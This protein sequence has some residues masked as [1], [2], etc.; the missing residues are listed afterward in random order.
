MIATGNLNEDKTEV[1]DAL[2]GKTCADLAELPNGRWGAVGANLD[3]IPVV[4]GG[5]FIIGSPEITKACFKFTNGEWKEFASMKEGR[6]WAAGIVYKN[7][8]H[9][10]GGYNGNT[11]SKRLSSSEIISIEGG[12]ESGPDMADNIEYHAITTINATTSILSGG[13][14]LDGSTISKTWY[15]NHETQVFTDGP[16]LQEGRQ[17]HGSAT[18]RDRNNSLRIPI[19]TGG[20]N[21]DNTLNSTEL[22]INGKWQTGTISWQKKDPSFDF[23]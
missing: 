3:G 21:G 22:L 10:F 18:I 11:A 13:L 23:L 20:S 1:V 8:F 14:N 5:L 6:V 17:R 7:K 16:K 12:V 19:V 15:Y 9:I 4:C 2:S